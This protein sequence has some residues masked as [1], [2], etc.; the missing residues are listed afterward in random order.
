MATT[1]WVEALALA[2]YLLNRRPCSTI[3]N[4]IPYRLLHG[5]PPDYLTSAPSVVS[6]ILTCPPHHPTSYHLVPSYVSSSA[7]PP[8]IRGITALTCPLDVSSSLDMSSSKSHPSPSLSLL[9]RRS[10]TSCCHLLAPLQLHPRSPH[11]QTLSSGDLYHLF[12]WSYPR[13]TLPSL[14][15]VLSS[16]WRLWPRHLCPDWAGLF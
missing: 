7:I 9:H 15:A 10:F 4:G 6:A 13:M 16:A 11:P 1:Y 12:C 3:Q 14:Y 8:L 5:Q 2:T